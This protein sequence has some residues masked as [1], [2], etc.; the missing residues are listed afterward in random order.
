M[1]NMK[2]K[3]WPY[4]DDWCEIWGKDIATGKK[5]KSFADM[6]SR[7]MPHER[8][9]QTDSDL[10]EGYDIAA[11]D[12]QPPKESVP[13]GEKSS[14]AGPST[15]GTEAQPS[16]G[17]EATGTEDQPTQPK[18][19]VR[20]YIPDICEGN[21]YPKKRKMKPGESQEPFAKMMAGF[22]NFTNEAVTSVR[23]LAGGS[24]S[25]TKAS[26]DGDYV[27]M[28]YDELN[29][30]PLLP[31]HHKITIGKQLLRD[32]T[33]LQFFLVM[34]QDDKFTFVNEELML[35]GGDDMSLGY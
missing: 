24:S 2:D 10:E 1:V 18:S 20:S 6:N 26:T 13:A 22:V 25:G 32:K 8:H 21:V 31:S 14:A 11:D 28:L 27:S 29:K 16:E 3:K 5:A 9:P 12:T 30:F 7:L 35:L 33:T 19:K 23:G 17:N 34:N 15:G 4:F